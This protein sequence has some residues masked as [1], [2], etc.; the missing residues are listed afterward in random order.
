[1]LAVD[2]V[3]GHTAVPAGVVAVDISH[4]DEAAVALCEHCE[5]AVAAFMPPPVQNGP[6]PVFQTAA[7]PHCRSFHWGSIAQ[8]EA[9]LTDR[10]CGQ[11][12]VTHVDICAVS[13][14][15]QDNGSRTCLLFYMLISFGSAFD[16]SV[17]VKYTV[18]TTYTLNLS[19]GFSS[20]AD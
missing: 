15:G 11:D 14:S 19:Q 1:M 8:Q 3:A 16:T 20:A 9:R 4:V 18:T 6:G 2:G 5:V 12:R 10:N 13:I 17:V 7:H